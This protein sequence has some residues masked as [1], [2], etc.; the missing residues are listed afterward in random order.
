MNFDQ[1]F[2]ALIGNEGGYSYD[3]ADPGGETMWGIT[4]RVARRNG[5][6][7]DMRTLSRDTA[8]GIAEHE[9]WMPARCDDLPPILRFQMLDAAYNS[10]ATQAA[11]WLQ[12]ALDVTADGVLGPAT[13]AAA[14]AADP[15][16]IAI[17]FDSQRL[18]F[19]TDRPTWGMFGRGWAKRI[20]RNLRTLVTE[21]N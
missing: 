7:G 9:Y 18:D 19:L 21:R 11:L 3:P 12:R 20:A 16:V 10:G 15:M 1:A 17:L 6:T 4:A 14:A 2:D 13:L 8:K 5:Y